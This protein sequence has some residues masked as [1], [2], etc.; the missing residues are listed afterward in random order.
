[1]TTGDIPAADHNREVMQIWCDHWRPAAIA[2]AKAFSP[3][4]N[5]LAP[6]GL[7]FDDELAAACTAQA[8]I[9]TALGLVN[10]DGV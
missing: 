3:V 1:M 6:R 2:A 4:F 7:S 9:V 10:K 5:R 8:D